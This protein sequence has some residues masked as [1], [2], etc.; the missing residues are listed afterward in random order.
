[1]P[2][3]ARQL[4]RA[5]AQDHRF[6]GA[7]DA[8]DNPVLVPERTRQLLLLRIHDLDQVGNLQWSGDR[9]AGVE[10]AELPPRPAPREF[11]ETGASARGRSAATSWR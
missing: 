3:I 7:G 5:K 2:S 6:A 8:V 1:M 11:R 4:H 10:Q 9:A